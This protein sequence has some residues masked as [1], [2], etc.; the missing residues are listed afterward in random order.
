MAGKYFMMFLLISSMVGIYH[1]FGFEA[2]ITFIA[3]CFVIDQL[4]RYN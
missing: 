1:F 2:A 3:G 4:M